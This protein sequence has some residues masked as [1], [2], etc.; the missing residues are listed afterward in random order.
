[1]QIRCG[2]FYVNFQKKFVVGIDFV[3]TVVSSAYGKGFCRTGPWR[4]GRRHEFGSG[5]Q[6]PHSRKTRIKAPSGIRA[7]LAQLLVR[8]EHLIRLCR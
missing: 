3:D 4:R 6:N 5:I 2:R 7:F 1:M 8:W